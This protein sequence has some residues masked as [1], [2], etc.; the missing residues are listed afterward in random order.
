MGPSLLAASKLGWVPK[1]G[2]P[3]WF[4][5]RSFTPVPP[6][7]GIFSLG[8]RK[9]W[10][11]F[12]PLGDTRHIDREDVYP[13]KALEPRD[14]KARMAF[15]SSRAGRTPRQ[16]RRKKAKRGGRGGWC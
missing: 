8:N 15:Q 14:L 2:D 1:P 7:R 6:V 13:R 4:Y 5:P 9:F 16:L 3:V 12:G 11:I 10:V